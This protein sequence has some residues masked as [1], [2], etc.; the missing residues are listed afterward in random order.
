[1]VHSTEQV[2]L[3]ICQR[4]YGE[5][6]AVYL[7]GSH[8]RGEADPNSDLDLAILFDYEQAQ[9]VG[10]LS[11]SEAALELARVVG[12]S[13]DLVNLRQVSTVFQYQII[14]T[15][16]LL[17]A[18]PGSTPY[19]FEGLVVSLYQ[20]LLAERLRTDELIP[21]TEGDCRSMDDDTLNKAANT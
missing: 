1:M 8:A 10:E 13:V 18:G 3:E 9:A 19:I 5:V 7:F 11:L 15:G 21:A 4:H 16:K 17:F 12:C 2:I 6:E 20:K 14:T